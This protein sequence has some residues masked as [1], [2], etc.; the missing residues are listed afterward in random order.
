MTNV[1]LSPLT[2][3]V[4]ASR[5]SAGRAFPP[6]S[7][8]VTFHSPSIFLTP[9]LSSFFSLSGA[10]TAPRVTVK[11][12]TAIGGSISSV[13]SG[14]ETT[15]DMIAGPDALSFLNHAPLPHPPPARRARRLRPRSAGRHPVAAGPKAAAVECRWADTPIILDGTDDDPAWKHAQVIDAFG[16]PW[17]GDKAPALRGKTRAKLLWD[18]DYLYFFAEMEDTDLFA[19]V[20]E[21][22]GDIWKNDVFELFFRPAA[23]KPGYFEFEVN[24]ANT[25]LDAFFPKRDLDTIR[26]SRSRSASSASRRRSSSAGRSTSGTTRT[27][28]GAS[29]G[30]SRGPTSCAPAAGRSPASSGG[31]TS[32][33]CNYHKD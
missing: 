14:W 10:A 30:A 16:Q 15:A 27:R 7:Q 1:Y 32:C 20:T 23:D 17:L 11:R 33:R 21:H 25:V 24:A 2:V 28:A 31:S 4:D 29:R 26:A 19:D 3:Q 5:A 22:D 12:A 13:G 8:A 6:C 9:S 18:R